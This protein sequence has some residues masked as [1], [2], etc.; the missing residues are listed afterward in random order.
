M[1]S[2]VS[3][4][5]TGFLFGSKHMPSFTLETIRELS[6]RFGEQAAA[7][8]AKHTACVSSSSILFLSSLEK[9]SLLRDNVDLL[10]SLA[11]VYFRASDT[12]NAILKFEQAQM[13]DPY[14]IKG[15]VFISRLVV[16]V[17]VSTT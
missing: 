13:L 12:K 11:D 9:K 14:L 7:F 8:Y 10:V 5:W 16:T 17:D 15:T 4:T 2:R 6:T 3:P 1:L